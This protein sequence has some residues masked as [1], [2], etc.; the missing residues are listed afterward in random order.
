MQINVGSPF[1]ILNGSLRIVAVERRPPPHQ[2]DVAVARIKHEH[3]LQNVFRGGQGTACAQRLR[4][5]AEDFPRFFLFAQFDV[6]LGEFD[7]HRHVFRVHF[8][9]LLEQAH[10]LLH[11]P[12]LHEFFGNLQILRPRIIEEALLG[13]ELR[14]LQRSIHARLELGDLLVH[15]NALDRKTLRRIGIADRFETFDGLFGIAQPR[16]QIANRIG[17]CK[18]LFIVFA[19]LLVF[20]DSILQLALLNEF[21]RG[22][23]NLLFVKT[24]NKRHRIYGLQPRLPSNAHFP[25]SV[26]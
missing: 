1:Q 13:V 16:V 26:A 7:P 11:V 21:F 5:R 24:E 25:G 23:E 12:T 18:I 2:Q 3:T 4:C 22:A 19:D 15:G 20:S 10:C 8:K 9:N 6:N 17:N 14:Q